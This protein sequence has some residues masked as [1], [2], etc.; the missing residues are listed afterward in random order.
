MA[1]G[2]WPGGGQLTKI[3]K[4]ESLLTGEREKGVGGVAQTE[5]KINI[6]GESQL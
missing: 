1:M 5:T 3:N 6:S 2:D 4:S